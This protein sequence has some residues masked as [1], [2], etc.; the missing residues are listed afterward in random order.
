[1]QVRKAKDQ[2]GA[3]CCLPP[4]SHRSLFH[5]QPCP[6]QWCHGV[7]QA[8]S[9]C[10]RAN[11]ASSD[12]AHRN[13]SQANLLKSYPSQSYFYSHIERVF[14]TSILGLL[15]PTLDALQTPSS[16]WPRSHGFLHPFKAS[17]RFSF[18]CYLSPPTALHKHSEPTPFYFIR[19]HRLEI[20]HS[21][22]N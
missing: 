13:V 4:S 1:M 18:W 21:V 7:M 19:C 5:M 20:L 15:L 22:C 10:H 16:W 17:Y 12:S 2:G 14:S 9:S 3:D 6:A 11:A 8:M